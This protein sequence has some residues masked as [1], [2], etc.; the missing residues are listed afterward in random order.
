MAS[1]EKDNGGY[2]SCSYW[3]PSLEIDGQRT[4][5]KAFLILN[6]VPI[7]FSIAFATANSRT[8]H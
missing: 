1:L 8:A 7:D 4:M 5:D 2:G 6:F 3:A